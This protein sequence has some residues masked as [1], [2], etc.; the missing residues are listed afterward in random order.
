MKKFILI[1]LAAGGVLSVAPPRASAQLFSGL[2]SGTT[3]ATYANPGAVPTNYT[4][5]GLN[6]GD[7]LVSIDYF[8]SGDGRLYGFGNSGTLYSLASS[9]ATYAA[10]VSA[11]SAAPV[12]TGATAIDFNP[13]AGR[14]RIFQGQN[15]FRLTP[16]TGLQ[17]NDGT[18]A[19]VANDP[20]TGITPTLLAAAYTNNVPGSGATSL[21]S[22]DTGRNTLMLHSGTP[23]FST[24]QTVATLTLGGLTF[25]AVA[26]IGFDIAGAST[27][28]LSQGNTLYSVN[29]GSGVMT[30]LGAQSGAAFTDFA[31]IPEPSTYALFAVGAL[32]V[33]VAAVRRRQTAA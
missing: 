11:T 29:L 21:Y 24:I 33:G 23:T 9:G 27:A 32:A 19:Y 4:V 10:T 17:S 25:D 14:L 26:G 22:I 30:S 13:A 15:N 20:G 5:T 6:A 1:L 16:G 8:A 31:V 28:Y 7:T 18:F 2:T 12:I 3:I